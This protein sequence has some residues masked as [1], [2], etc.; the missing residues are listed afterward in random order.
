MSRPT[1]VTPTGTAMWPKVFQPEVSK[2]YPS[3]EHPEGAYS[4]QLR[5]SEAE[6]APLRSF[7]EKQMDAHRKT[8]GKIRMEKHLKKYP[9]QKEKYAKI[10]AYLA[11][12]P[13]PENDLPVN[14]VLDEM[15]EPT[16]EWEFKFNEWGNAY[17]RDGEG[18]IVKTYPNTIII[19]DAKNRPFDKNNIGNGSLIRIAFVIFAYQAQN[20]GLKLIPVGIQVIEHVEYASKKVDFD[21]TDGYESDEEAVAEAENMFTREEADVPF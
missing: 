3:K 4:I 5:L 17:K 10:D 14:P 9:K 16:G 18:N 12:H 15:G 8:V 1:Q 19:K 11:E 21:V 6:A 7:L 20:I 13:V 2:K